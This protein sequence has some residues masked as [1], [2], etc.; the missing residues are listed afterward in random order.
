MTTE[1]H[2]DVP[3]LRTKQ[4]KA[5]GPSLQV[6]Q[7]VTNK[8]RRHVWN[9]LCR[10]FVFTRRAM[11]C[12]IY[13]WQD[14]TG[15]NTPEGSESLLEVI[16]LCFV[17][18]GVFFAEKVLTH[19]HEFG[20]RAE[21]NKRP[22]TFFCCFFFFFDEPGG[23]TTSRHT[24]EK[25]GGKGASTWRT[26]SEIKRREGAA[27]RPRCYAVEYFSAALI[28]WEGVSPVAWLPFFFFLWQLKA[29]LETTCDS[30]PLSGWRIAFATC[31]VALVSLFSGVGGGRWGR[32]SRELYLEGR[33]RAHTHRNV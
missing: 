18:F 13:H 22:P 26:N 24:E 27:R 15:K 17:F 33:M 30:H 7:T 4:T 23:P 3:G 2:K 8:N 32:G 9:C 21:K 16:L 6:D 10:F 20:A 29:V 5:T 14:T 19:A 12:V 28:E 11:P 1:R 31:Q 25:S